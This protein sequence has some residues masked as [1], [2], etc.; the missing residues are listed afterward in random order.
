LIPLYL[1]TVYKKEPVFSHSKIVYTI[2]QT[3]FKEKLGNN[4]LKLAGLNGALKEKDLEILK[5]NNNLALMRAGA[6]YADAI[7]FG[8]DKPDKK[9]LDELSKVR[10]K[11]ILNY[12][13][14]SDLTD[15]LQLYSDLAK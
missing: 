3:T 10:G 15:Y 7:N 11:K 12:N 8:T 9:L 13:A 1:K 14:E 4:F 2:G 6:E 5:E